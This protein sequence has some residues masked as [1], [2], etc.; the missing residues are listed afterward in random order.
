MINAVLVEGACQL[1]AIRR[2]ERVLGADELEDVE[3]GE[4]RLVGKLTLPP[5]LGQQLIERRLVLGLGGEGA[6][7]LEASPAVVGLRCDTRFER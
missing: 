5:H 7:Q 2:G 3:H 4:A 6:S 1:S